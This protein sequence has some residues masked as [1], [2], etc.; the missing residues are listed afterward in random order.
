M[1][2]IKVAWSIKN[3]MLHLPMKTRKA[4]SKKKRKSILTELTEEFLSINGLQERLEVL[5]LIKIK[6]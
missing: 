1:L 4:K 5:C 2:N 6:V 3:K